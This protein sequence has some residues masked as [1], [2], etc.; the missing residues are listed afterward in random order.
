MAET[1]YNVA[2]GRWVSAMQSLSRHVSRFTGLTPDAANEIIKLA[3]DKGGAKSIAGWD[4]AIANAERNPQLRAQFVQDILAAAG[5]TTGEVNDQ[6]G[7][8]TRVTVGRPDH[9]PKTN[10]SGTP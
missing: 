7:G 9:W 3:M 5:A 10:Q 6:K 8:P 4:K 1:G 2:T